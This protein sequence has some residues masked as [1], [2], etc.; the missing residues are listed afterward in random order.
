MKYIKKFEESGV[1]QSTFRTN[2]C[3]NFLSAVEHN[4]LEKVKR[5]VKRHPGEIDIETTDG[6]TAL[7]WAASYGYFDIAKFL[8]DNGADINHKTPWNKT[9][10]YWAADSPY[11]NVNQLDIIVYLIEK[12][13]DKKATVLI[14]I[15]NLF[16]YVSKEAVPMWLKPFMSGIKQFIVYTVVSILIDWIVAKYNSGDWRKE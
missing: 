11:S 6:E 13:A 7:I 10:L 2:K 4:D 16:D 3:F 9:P 14:A 1:S 5:W 8:I 12:G 15:A